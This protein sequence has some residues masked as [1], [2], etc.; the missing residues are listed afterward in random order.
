MK[1]KILNRSNKI[2]SVCL[3]LFGVFYLYAGR[4][5]SF[6]SFSSPRTGFLPRVSA[7]AMLFL[8]I[9]NAIIE[10][11]KPAEIPDEF[12]EVNWLKAFLYIGCCALYVAMLSWGFG[13]IVATPICLLAMIKFTGIKGWVIPIITTIAVT[14]FFYGIFHSVMGVY[15][16][17][18]E[19]FIG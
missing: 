11:G 9:V 6:G 7:I 5:L 16:P 12:K 14:A 15:F 2:L 13:Y 4:G 18:P 10:I 19:L 3:I 8:A 17:R 1:E